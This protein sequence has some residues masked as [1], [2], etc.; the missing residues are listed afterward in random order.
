MWL[1]NFIRYYRWKRKQPFQLVCYSQDCML[2]KDSETHF[3]LWYGYW[4]DEAG[5]LVI[6]ID[7]SRSG[8][9]DAKTDSKTK[10]PL[11]PEREELIKE[12][13]KEEFRVRDRQVFLIGSYPCIEK[14]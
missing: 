13:I 4:Y 8:A 1:V 7:L 5:H 12:R 10:V 9:Y 3:Y 14:E 6:E 11:S 2:Y